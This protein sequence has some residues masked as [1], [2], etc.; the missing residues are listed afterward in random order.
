M[1]QVAMFS[2]MSSPIAAM[3]SDE[4]DKQLKITW[5]LIQ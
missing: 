1:E 5:M 2:N 4:A 3:V